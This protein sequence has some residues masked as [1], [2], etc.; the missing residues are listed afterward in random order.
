MGSYH[1]RQIA[2]LVLLLR[3][4]KF[5]F[6]NYNNPNSIFIFCRY[7]DDRFMLTNKAN[8]NNIITKLCAAYPTQ[9][10]VT[11][12]SSTLSKLPGPHHLTKLPYHQMSQSPLSSF[13][14][15]TSQIH[16]P[17]FLTQSPTSNF[18]RHNQDRNNPQQQTVQD[19]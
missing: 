5:F 18:F 3:E 12:S 17:S 14:K 15:T 13:S 7:V 1:S 2:D 19:D 16:V 10:P 8:T 9:I 4:F 6:N 11:F